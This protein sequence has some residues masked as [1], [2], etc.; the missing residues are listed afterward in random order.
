[1]EKNETLNKT[2]WV[3]CP[4]SERLDRDVSDFRGFQILKHRHRLYGLSSNPNLNIWNPKWS[5]IPNTLEWLQSWSF[6][7]GVLSQGM[8]LKEATGGLAI[9]FFFFFSPSFCLLHFLCVHSLYMVLCYRR[10]F[11]QLHFY[12]RTN[13]DNVFYLKARCHR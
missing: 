3:E 6:Q 12:V 5:K 11:I 8:S 1:M 7:I 4:L 2:I 10:I 9:S 13:L